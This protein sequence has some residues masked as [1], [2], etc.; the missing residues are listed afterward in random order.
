MIV[1]VTG[2]ISLHVGILSL[3]K[4][5]FSGSLGGQGGGSEAPRDRH[6]QRR[7]HGEVVTSALI[8]VENT[9]VL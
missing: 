6:R 1:V 8:S 4:R 2:V 5:V 9:A 7:H 3:G